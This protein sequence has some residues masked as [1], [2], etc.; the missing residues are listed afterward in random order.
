MNQLQ[1]EKTPAAVAAKRKNPD[2]IVTHANQTMLFKTQNQRVSKWLRRHYR[3][4][5]EDVKGDTE[6]RVH[7]SRCKRV[8]EELMA[9]GFGVATL[10]PA[11]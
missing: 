10:Q 8:V 5:A 1:T 11:K 9:V 2:V 4:S 7:P 3:M 6:I